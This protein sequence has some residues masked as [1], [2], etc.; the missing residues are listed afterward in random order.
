MK[1]KKM[2]LF[3]KILTFGQSYAICLAPFG[4]FI[5]DTWFDPE[6]INHEKI[7]WQQQ[8]E[9]LLIFFYLWYFFEWLVR[10]VTPPAGAYIC[11]SFEREAYENESNSEYLSIR[12][13]F[14]WWQYLT[15]RSN[16]PF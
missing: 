8:K 4:I 3:V 1:I 16:R 9:M 6:I 2:N 11:I 12:K 10:L 7:H 5:D 14:A 15:I 13:H